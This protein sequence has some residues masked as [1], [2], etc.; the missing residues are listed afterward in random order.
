MI[1]EFSFINEIEIIK[2]EKQINYI[3]AVLYWCDTKEIEIEMIADFI[4]KDPMLKSKIQ[5]DAED[6]NFIKKGN[7][8]PI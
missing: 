1:K 2:K 5:S 4:K 7:R 6:L 3:D 8:L